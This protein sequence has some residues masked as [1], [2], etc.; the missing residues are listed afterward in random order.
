MQGMDQQLD[1]WLHA[2]DQCQQ[3]CK[4]NSHLWLSV[5]TIIILQSLCMATENPSTFPTLQ[6]QKNIKR[7]CMLVII[8][9][10]NLILLRR[11]CT[12]LAAYVIQFKYFVTRS[13]MLILTLS[14]CMILKLH[15]HCLMKGAKILILKGT[16][17]ACSRFDIISCT[18]TMPCIF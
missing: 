7:S 11:A 3:S 12:Q 16:A 1:R 13:Y 10:P 14:F 18:C 5:N 15:V 4:E 17:H 2:C 8:F 9:Q 6:F